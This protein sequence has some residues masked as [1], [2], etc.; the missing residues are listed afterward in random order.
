MGLD[1]EIIYKSGKENRVA[2][3]LSRKGSDEGEIHALT[4]VE[5]TW[6]Q[7]VK[8]SWETDPQMTELIADLE[9]DAFKHPG[10]TWHNQL[11]TYEGRLAVGNSQQLRTTLMTEHHNTPTGGHFRYERTYR[12]LKEAFYWKGTICGQV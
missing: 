12:R 2:D 4:A 11:S 6:L 10:Y 3:A 9:Q 1:F 5:C 7:E 8:E